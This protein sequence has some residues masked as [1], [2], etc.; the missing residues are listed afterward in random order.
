MGMRTTVDLDPALL[1]RLRVE[2][3][4]RG[5]T[6]KELLAIALRRGLEEPAASRPFRMRTMRL[7]QAQAGVNLDKALA[8]AHTLEDEE[9]V[10]DLRLRK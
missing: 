6:V 4:R 5:V 8:V 2:A 7:G 9:T 10:R 1:K 3:R